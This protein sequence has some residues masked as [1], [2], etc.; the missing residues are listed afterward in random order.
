MV[1]S[2]ELLGYLSKDFPIAMNKIHSGQG[3][4]E[5]HSFMYNSFVKK[6]GMK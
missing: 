6:L 5:F 2:R 4:K 3:L 1:C